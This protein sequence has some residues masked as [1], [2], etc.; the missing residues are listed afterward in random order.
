MIERK[1]VKENLRSYLLEE[2]V[3]ETLKNVGL[4]HVKMTRTPL[5]EKILIYASRPGLVVGRKGENIKKLT[6]TLK[7]KF[8]LE[9]PQIEIVEVQ[10]PS[11]DARIVAER[12]AS[13]LERFGSQKFK[14][15][16]HKTMTEVMGSGALGIQITMSGKL[17][18]ARAK[19]WRFYMGYL[20]KSGQLNIE[21]VLHAKSVATLKSG[22]IGV[23]VWIMPP[24]VARPDD[25]HISENPAM[26]AVPTALEEKRPRRRSPRKKKEA[27]PEAKEGLTPSVETRP[28]AE[29]K[30]RP[31]RVPRKKK[32]AA[33]APAATPAQSPK[34]APAP[35]A[36]K[37]TPVA[38]APT[39][40]TEAP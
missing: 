21:G 15:I 23:Q 18:S 8:D 35:A 10:N 19:T 32:E 16:G 7:K 20:K 26:P 9:N 12:I 28:E 22:V 17:P 5:G 1:F 30:P 36:A 40:S 33:E 39:E 38:T 3:S 34:E 29:P 24:T 6:L 2:F 25:I 27:A 4:S 31:K 14:A 11:L 13:T 37:E